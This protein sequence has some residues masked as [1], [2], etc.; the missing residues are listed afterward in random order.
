MTLIGLQNLSSL[1]MSVVA[2]LCLTELQASMSVLSSM[3]PISVSRLP[4]LAARRKLEFESVCYSHNTTQHNTL[5]HAC[6]SNHC[7]GTEALG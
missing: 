7:S 2:R 6:T 4:A 5:H 1:L 3:R